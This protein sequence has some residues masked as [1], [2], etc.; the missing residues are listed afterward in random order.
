MQWALLCSRMREKKACKHVKKKCQ[1]VK[2]VNLEAFDAI[3]ASGHIKT[4]A[5]LVVRRGALQ[6]VYKNKG[7]SGSR[8]RMLARH[9]VN[10]YSCIVTTLS[11]VSPRRLSSA[12]CNIASV[13]ITRIAVLT[14]D[15]APSHEKGRSFV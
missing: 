8:L 6:L 12:V 9:G 3:K 15:W 5:Q 13:R 7:Q 4:S 11:V 14:L 1:A 2:D 10:Q